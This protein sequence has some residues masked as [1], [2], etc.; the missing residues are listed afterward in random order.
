MQI[1]RPSSGTAASCSDET[2]KH[3]FSRM[4]GIKRGRP[5]A[6]PEKDTTS[7]VLSSRTSCDCSRLY[8]SVQGHAE[9]TPATEAIPDSGF[10]DS[11]ILL[12]ARRVQVTLVE[13]WCEWLNRMV[14]TLEKED[15]PMIDRLEAQ[16][17]GW[18]ACAS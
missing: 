9:S 13:T 16:L 15:L 17:C 5:Q 14:Q 4:Q 8:L 18:L 2:L 1:S 11:R 3:A 7:H 10:D 12:A 6:L